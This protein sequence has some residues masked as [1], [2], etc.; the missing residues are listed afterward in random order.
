MKKR[1]NAQSGVPPITTAVLMVSTALAYHVGAR[2]AGRPDATAAPAPDHP[3]TR[4]AD[5][6][7]VQERI[8]RSGRIRRAADAQYAPPPPVQSMPSAA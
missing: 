7:R 6:A 4:T 5:G 2:A 8:A 1:T 3:I